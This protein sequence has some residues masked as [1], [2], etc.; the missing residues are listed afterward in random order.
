MVQPEILPHE[1]LRQ[2]FGAD[3]A[4]YGGVSTRQTL[5]HGTV[6]EVRAACASATAEL[7]RD[8]TGLLFGPSHRLMIDI[9]EENLLALVDF[10]RDPGGP[11]AP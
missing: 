1:M 10:I 7:G 11:H 8:G 9:P 6:A 3:L 2:E 5:P 4:F